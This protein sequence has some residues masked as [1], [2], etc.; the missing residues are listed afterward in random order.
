MT[1]D[2]HDPARD[3]DRT[4]FERSQTVLAT[5]HHREH[6]LKLALLA[7]GVRVD[8]L[9]VDVELALGHADGHLHRKR[10]L[11]DAG[12]GGDAGAEGSAADHN[13]TSDAGQTLHHVEGVVHWVLG[14]EGGGGD[15]KLPRHVREAAV[16]QAT[17]DQPS[18]V[19]TIEVNRLSFRSW[20]C[21]LWLESAD[22][23]QELLV[24]G[25]GRSAS[26][27]VLL[28]RCHRGARRKACAWP[29]LLLRPRE[30]PLQRIVG[31]GGGHVVVDGQGWV[32]AALAVRVCRT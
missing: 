31:S 18:R 22:F 9:L 25:G 19:D 16:R 26:R 21:W 28:R 20:L 1:H 17:N 4:S 10:Q 32:R 23:G 13:D 8:P 14:E 29:S 24:R 5:L 3:R 2:H 11:P 12:D 27:V 15:G 30:A 6:L 7:A